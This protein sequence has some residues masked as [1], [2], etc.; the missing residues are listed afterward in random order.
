MLLSQPN[1]QA[2]SPELGKFISL[3]LMKK[4]KLTLGGVFPEDLGLA[5][6]EGVQHPADGQIHLVSLAVTPHKKAALYL[7]LHHCFLHFKPKP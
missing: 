4:G 1:W 2:I 6:A 7:I 5:G 3:P